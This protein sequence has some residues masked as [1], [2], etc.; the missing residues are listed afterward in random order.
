MIEAIQTEARR[1]FDLERG[2]LI[3]VNV[4]RNNDRDCA[5]VIVLHHAVSDAWSLDI[6]F[7]E[8]EVCYRAFARGELSPELPKMPVQY[9]DYARWHSAVGCTVMF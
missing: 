1:P 4:V 3:R 9:F 5:L 6:L 2:P 8:L 7:R